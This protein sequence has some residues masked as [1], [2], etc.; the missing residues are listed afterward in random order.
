MTLLAVMSATTL[1]GVI[2]TTDAHAFSRS[3]HGGTYKTVTKMVERT[4]MQRVTTMR[5]VTKL[6]RKTIKMPYSYKQRVLETKTTT[7]P[8]KVRVPTVSHK[9]VAMKVCSG[10]GRRSLLSRMRS[11]HGHGHVVHAAPTCKT[12]HKRVAVR[13]FRMET[14][15]VT[16]KRRVWVTKTMTRTPTRTVLA[17]ETVMRPVTTLKRVKTMVPMKVRVR[18]AAPRVMKSRAVKSH[19]AVRSHRVS[20]KRSRHH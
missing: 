6:V 14:R 7:H 12:V 20:H 10:G 1:S 15:M 19:R 11:R 16:S 3:H 17:R 5:P 9:T 4:T 18:V 8:A 2:G 13:G